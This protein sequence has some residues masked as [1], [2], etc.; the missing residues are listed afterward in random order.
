MGGKFIH[1]FCGKIR[2]KQTTRVADPDVD[3]GNI[4]N[5][6]REVGSEGGD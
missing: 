6:L 1:R 5:D 3:R 4:R 2:K